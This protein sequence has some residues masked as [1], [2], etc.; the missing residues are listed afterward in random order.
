MTEISE[1][2]NNKQVDD[3]NP[4]SNTYAQHPTSYQVNTIGCADEQ[5]LDIFEGRQLETSVV[6]E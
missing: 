1:G 6:G 3:W 4:N 5:L 2:D